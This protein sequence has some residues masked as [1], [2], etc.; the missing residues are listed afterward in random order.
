M[1]NAVIMAAGTSSR[2]APL[3]YEQPKGL[4]KVKGEI[5]IER[6]IRQLREVGITDITVV[7]GYMREKFFYLKDK[8]GV[9]IV[10]NEDYYK[11]NNP[12]TL[13]RVLDK[14][15]NTYICSSDNYFVENVFE[16]SVDHA[17]YSAVYGEG[18]TE[19]YCLT[20]DSDGRITDV[21]V[22][23]H[24]SWYMLGQVY[25]DEA[26]SS[27]FKKILVAE[28]EEA[29]GELWEKLYMKHLD[30]LDMHIRKYD[31]DKVLE[32]DSLDE[33]RV[34]D[35]E[36]IN[37][38]DSRILQNICRVLK[39][40]VKEIIEIQAMETD[41]N[42]KSFKFTVRDE[43]YIY[44]HLDIGTTACINR[45]SKALSMRAPHELGLDDA[46]IYMDGKE[47]WKISKYTSEGEKNDFMTTKQ[48]V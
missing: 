39:C 48:C 46:F 33:L 34:F 9:Q 24:D 25:F 26:F 28:Y 27:R 29:K 31:A 41:R 42:N 47:G 21:S 1:I 16:K 40:E 7:V 22:G 2:F 8:Y 13:I 38:A 20:T 17:Y 3:S 19:E 45:E 6:E 35:S 44:C 14:L 43:D 5:L 32:F 11:Y 18:E 15:K 23:G 37:Y 30:E 4:L 36:Y 10:V 12:S